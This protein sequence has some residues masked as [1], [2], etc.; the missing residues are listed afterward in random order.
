[1]D[2]T[3]RAAPWHG[4]TTPITF[5]AY[6]S[7]VRVLAPNLCNILTQILGCFLSLFGIGIWL[8]RTS[9]ILEMLSSYQHTIIGTKRKIEK[10]YI[11]VLLLACFD[12]FPFLIA[13]V[14]GAQKHDPGT[15]N[16]RTVS[17]PMHTTQA[18]ALVHRLPKTNFM[19]N[20]SKE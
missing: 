19:F 20:Y 13:I 7:I 10:A 2:E 6:I 17:T 14:W 5:T 11:Q 4:T 18:C 1:M 8:W 15:P 3:H 16:F 12:A 9:G